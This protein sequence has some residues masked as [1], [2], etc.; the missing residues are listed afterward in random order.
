LVSQQER[1]RR[2][3]DLREAMLDAGYHV[4]VL[5]G[6]AEATQRGYIRYVS[7]WRLW[8]GNGYVVFPL[9]DDPVLVLGSGSQAYWA[10]AVG[11]IQ[12]VRSAMDKPA[13]VV[14]TLKRLGLASSRIGVV[15]LDRVMSYQDARALIAPLTNA[16]LDDA[17]HLMDDVMA[18]KSDEEIAR[19][20]ETYRIVAQAHDRIRDALAPGRTERAVMS[21]AV[22]FLAERGCL[23]GIAHLSNE[24]PPFV[25]P[26]EDRTITEDDILKVSLEFAGPA[27]YWIELASIFSFRKPPERERRYFETT[28]RAVERA[29]EL[30][31]PGTTGGELSTAIEDTYREDGWDITGRVIWDVHGIGL[32]VIT[33]PIGLPGS[34]DV[35][36][37]NMILNI[38]PGLV[39]GEDGWGVYVQDNIVVTPEGGRPLA[40]Y[41]YEWHVLSG[42]S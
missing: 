32:N 26:P 25:R 31:R 20:A 5:A 1:E 33:P 30:M 34:A 23:D 3:S 8:G 41:E 24:A 12:H 35:L 4:L 22:E 11:W 42:R 16:E 21:A 37:E 28:L 18:I 13:E 29:A 39:V 27:G 10:R 36:K 2:Y 38:H 14:D 40:D 17:T 19:A 15:G 9:N 6:N 7:D